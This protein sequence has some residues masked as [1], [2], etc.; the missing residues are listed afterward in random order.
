MSKYDEFIKPNLEEIKRFVSHGVTEKEVRDFYGVGK[1][2]WCEYKKKYS[3]LNELLC[4]AKKICRFNLENRAYEVAY[5]YEYIET[6][7]EEFKDKEGNITGTKTKVVKKYAK[8]D[9]GMLQFLLIN[10]YPE[11]FAR[12]PQVLN[13]RKKALKNKGDNADGQTT[14][15]VV[16]I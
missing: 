1:T 3:E 7:T 15:K 4:N 6:T 10:R 5:G 14:D 16:G 11:D 8:A 2:M 13:L 9:A 12:D